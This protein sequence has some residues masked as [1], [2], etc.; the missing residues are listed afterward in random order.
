MLQGN[1]LFPFFDISL[2]GFAIDP[3]KLKL[4]GRIRYFFN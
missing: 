3:L 4:T 2:L 1:S